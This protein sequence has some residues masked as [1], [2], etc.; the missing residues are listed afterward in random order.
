MLRRGSSSQQ[1]GE[2]YQEYIKAICQD[3]IYR[4]FPRQLL[5]M[6][7]SDLKATARSNVPGAKKAHKLLFDKFFEKQDDV[8]QSV[9]IFDAM[10]ILENFKFNF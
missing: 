3:R 2:T 5:E 4:E 8:I 1:L 7:V 10:K 6:N 9:T